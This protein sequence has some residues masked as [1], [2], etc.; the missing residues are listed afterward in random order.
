M[1]HYYI[2]TGP[3]P[4]YVTGRAPCACTIGHDHS[5][6]D[7]KYDIPG[8]NAAMRMHL[9]DHHGIPWDDTEGWD[10]GA[11]IGRHVELHGQ[12]VVTE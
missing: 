5:E 12:R 4:D 11:S 8:S 3:G 7:H 6:P 1:T 10:W 2:T 9:E